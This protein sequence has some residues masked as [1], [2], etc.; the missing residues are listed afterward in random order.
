MWTSAQ[1]ETS[2]RPNMVERT[3]KLSLGVNRSA[4][5]VGNEI[6]GWLFIFGD[7]AANKRP[8]PRDR[9]RPFSVR[10]DYCVESHLSVV[11]LCGV[12]HLGGRDQMLEAPLLS[13]PKTCSRD[14]VCLRGLQSAVVV[15]QNKFGG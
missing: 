3:S 6:R 2:A 7:A 13:K 8:D 1:G 11:D 10:I 14:P 4:E 9:L 5:A 12:A 15:G